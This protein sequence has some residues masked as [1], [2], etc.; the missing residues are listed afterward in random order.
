MTIGILVSMAMVALGALAVPPV[1][2][3]DVLRIA[4]EG[5]YPPFNWRETDGTLKGSTLLSQ[6]RFVKR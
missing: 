6:M 5:A 4:T 2:A 3:Q 1:L